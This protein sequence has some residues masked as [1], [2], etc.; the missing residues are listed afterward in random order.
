MEPQSFQLYVNTI[1]PYARPA[2]DHPTIHCLGQWA[3]MAGVSEGDIAV[4]I[5]PIGDPLPGT[6]VVVRDA[7]LCQGWPV[8]SLSS[9]NWRY[10]ITLTHHRLQ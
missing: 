1:W 7:Q 3:S 10:L 6:E 4:G 9:E 5:V 2:A 8:H